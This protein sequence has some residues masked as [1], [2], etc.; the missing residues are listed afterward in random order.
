MENLIIV[1][2]YRSTMFCCFFP[3]WRKTDQRKAREQ[4]LLDV[5]VSLAGKNEFNNCPTGLEF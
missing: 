5:L 4:K 1:A 2:L 3:D